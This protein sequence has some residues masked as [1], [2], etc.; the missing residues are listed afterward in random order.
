[1]SNPLYG[2]YHV[3]LKFYQ[4][5]NVAF[6]NL[7]SSHKNHIYVE[8]DGQVYDKIHF[9]YTPNSPINRSD[10]WT[11]PVITFNFDLQNTNV[12]MNEF[13]IF[14]GT[15]TN[16]KIFMSHAQYLFLI[17][18]SFYI[19]NIV[20]VQK[21]YMYGDIFE[22]LERPDYSALSIKTLCI[23]CMWTS[24]EDLAVKKY[25]KTNNLLKDNISNYASLHPDT[26]V[27]IKLRLYDDGNQESI[28]ESLHNML[29]TD[30]HS[31]SNIKLLVYVVDSLEYVSCSIDKLIINSDT[32]TS[33]LDVSVCDSK[34]Y[35]YNDAPVYVDL[36]E[37][38]YYFKE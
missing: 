10:A 20:E 1:V 11:Y 26:D 16:C 17:D 19:D 8:D 2:D 31:L 30:F 4:P 37:N 33:V 7:L 22:I 28:L 18:H 21:F 27:I 3:T 14:H 23:E 15:F 32:I 35:N 9:Y 13:T 12:Y 36:N 29:L 34:A 5:E 24:V 38:I 25:N 6:V